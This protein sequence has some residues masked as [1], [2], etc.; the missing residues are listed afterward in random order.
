[1]TD[2]SRHLALGRI[3][4]LSL[5]LVVSSAAFALGDQP[6]VRQQ[7]LGSGACTRSSG[8]YDPSHAASCGILDRYAE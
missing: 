1:M 5:A 2:D 8:P 4:V 6:A 3:S 7:A